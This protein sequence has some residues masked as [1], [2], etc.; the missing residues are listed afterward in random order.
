MK[1]LV[2][3]L[4]LSLLTICVFGQ[5]K[6][7]HDSIAIV[8][9]DRMSD[10]IGDMAS[11]SFKLHVI[12]DIADPSVGLIKQF[13][14]YEVYMTGPDKMLVE[15]QG[16][17]GHRQLMYNGKQ[18]AYYSFDE[19]NY[20]ILPAPETIIKTID[21][22]NDQYGIEFPAAD[23][24]YPAFTDD[25]LESADSILFLGTTLIQDKEYFH[26]LAKGKN[27]NFQFWVNN[28]PYNLP[29]R[30][31]ITY[32]NQPGNPQYVASF[33]DWQINP[34]LPVAMFDFQPPPGARPVRILAKDE[35]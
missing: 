33:S 8:I 30:F 7:Q 11:C 29:A 21:K 1:K 22:I 4:F 12:N 28:D 16:Y 25:L 13:N 6:K 9:M 23:F 3:V 35:R 31:A 2:V 34:T 5:G 20:G 15:A 27:I 10:V 26:I 18:L 19:K 32:K 17:K 24:F 14:D